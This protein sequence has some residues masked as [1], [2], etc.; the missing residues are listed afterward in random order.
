MADTIKIKAF[1]NLFDN[2]LLMR[3]F[4]DH[5]T[6]RKMLQVAFKRQAIEG[7]LELARLGDETWKLRIRRGED[8]CNTEVVEQ[9]T[10]R[11]FVEQD[12]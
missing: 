7:H 9:R 11:L 3:D 12:I 1:R 8:A 4:K 5:K 2:N 10:A 6:L